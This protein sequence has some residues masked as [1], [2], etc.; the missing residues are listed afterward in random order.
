M[1]FTDIPSI[2]AA[3]YRHVTGDFRPT[4]PRASH[5][6]S[7]TA[8]SSSKGKRPETP[9]L[10]APLEHSMASFAVTLL[11]Y[12][13]EYNKGD[14]LWI[15]TPEQKDHKSNKI[16]D[17]TIEYI[18]THNPNHI[19]DIHPWL[20]AE[21]KRIGGHHPCEALKQLAD[22]VYPGLTKD[23]K[24]RY[25][26]VAAGYNIGLFL[27]SQEPLKKNGKK[28][29]TLWNCI[30]L[31][32]PFIYDTMEHK[33]RFPDPQNTEAALSTITN[34]GIYSSKPKS[35]AWKTASKYNEPVLFN[36]QN[37]HHK[38]LL[39][40]IL[41]IMATVHPDSLFDP[42]MEIVPD[43]SEMEIVPDDSEGQD[44]LQQLG[45]LGL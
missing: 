41:T 36:I 30:P 25:L 17:Y 20:S 12:V 34:P 44:D 19:L 11:N 22:S 1:D 5:P 33:P 45:D 26:M 23:N 38:D 15:Y 37:Y 16:P 13:F 29:K 3:L 43:D 10:S 32:L 9:P 4:S 27:I 28:I 18:H 31:T 14:N 7:T 2:N 39:M 24:T 42:E 8:A 40:D 21:F 35:E 6:F